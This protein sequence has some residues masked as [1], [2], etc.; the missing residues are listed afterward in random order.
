VKTDVP[1]TTP[2]PGQQRRNSP[3]S[4]I[5]VLEIGQ[6]ISAPYAGLLLAELGAEVIKIEPPGVGDSARNPEV[7][8]M[9]DDS[10][11]FVTFN[12]NK[13]SVVLDLRDA[14]HYEF[15]TNLARDADVVLTNMLP[16][17]AERLQIDAAVLRGLNP[18]L[19]TCSITGF[20][21]EDARSG[22]PSYDLTH[23]AL[24]GYLLFEGRPGDPPQRIC[25]PLADLATAQFAVNAILAALFARWV[26]GVGDDIEVPMYDSMLSLLTYTATLY[27]NTGKEPG[28]AGAAHEYTAP[29]QA[30]SAKDGD[31]VLA[32]RSEKFWHRLCEAIGD[33]AVAF[34]P[35]FDTNSRRLENRV[36]MTEMLNAHFSGKTVQEWLTALRAAGVPA[37]PVRTVAAALDEAVATGSELIQEIEHQQLGRLR[38]VG[39]PVR[40]AG[41]DLAY[42][43]RPPALDEHAEDL[44]LA[45]RS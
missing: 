2:A 31:L 22:E 45:E 34:D 44:G 39:N 35:L 43:T 36:A 24:A 12:R 33:P 41:M 7:T 21:S 29:W 6:V 1:A 14:R 42:P 32:V 37:A 38:V 4:G 15:F 17:A 19:V 10:A 18:R 3:L 9:G 11:T 25:I 8:G 30:V 40:F 16:A 23:Q 13:K 27:L 5:R 28:R 26:T 20:R